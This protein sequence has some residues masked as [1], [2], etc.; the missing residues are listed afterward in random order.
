MKMYHDRETTPLKFHKFYRFVYLPYEIYLVISGIIG[1]ISGIEYFHF[2]YVISLTYNLAV[3]IC[4]ITC[5]VGIKA[6]KLYAWK[7]LITSRIILLTFGALLLWLA[8]V[9][10]PKHIP[11]QIELFLSNL[12]KSV[13]ILIYYLKRRNLFLPQDTTQIPDAKSYPCPTC[14]KI[15]SR[16]VS[17]CPFCGAVLH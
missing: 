7:A 14:E 8:F 16:E 15:V 6:W 11:V 2:S 5:L 1:I 12:V 9:L 17:I 4:L 10:S 3:L 13:P